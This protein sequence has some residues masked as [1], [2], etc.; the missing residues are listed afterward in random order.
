MIKVLATRTLAWSVIY[1]LFHLCILF[2]TPVKGLLKFILDTS[3][4]SKKAPRYLTG[5]LATS[6][7]NNMCGFA[8]TW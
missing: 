1:L 8:P 7:P 6:T 2:L 4:M 5:L 3:V